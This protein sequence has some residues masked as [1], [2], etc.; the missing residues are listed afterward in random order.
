MLFNTVYHTHPCVVHA[1]GKLAESPWWDIIKE[2]V[3][4]LKR[5]YARD[6]SLEIITWNSG[7]PDP[8]L[9]VR[10][11]T[12]GWFE[13]SL[14]HAGV[15]H[16]VL[17]RDIGAGWTNRRKLDL[18]IEFLTR[19]RAAFILGGDSSDVLLISDPRVLLERFVQQDAGMVFNAEKNF[20]PPELRS[21]RRFE[22]RV[23]QKPFGY[24]N[25]GL[26][27]G[28]RE[29]CLRAFRVAKSWSDKLESR[30]TSDQICWKHAYRDLYPTVK[31]DHSCEIFQSLNRVSAEIE[32][33]GKGLPTDVHTRDVDDGSLW[34]RMRGHVTKLAKRSRQDS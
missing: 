34:R 26:W 28:R 18:T 27:I 15:R 2:Q 33:N 8:I 6:D 3:F 9:S 10:G 22:N 30:P 12:L 4:A 21:L 24:F 11:H 25:S 13:K 5:A 1:P 29:A 17:G 7:A 19:S 31:A 16:A 32:V 23:G 20:W 14:T